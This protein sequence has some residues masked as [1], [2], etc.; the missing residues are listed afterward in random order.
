MNRNIKV[1]INVIKKIFIKSIKVIFSSI[2]LFDEIKLKTKET[3]NIKTIKIFLKKLS[4]INIT[5]LY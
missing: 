5:F 1:I 4:F 3:K 2:I